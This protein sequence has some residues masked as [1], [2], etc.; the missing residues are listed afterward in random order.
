MAIIPAYTCRSTFSG[1]RMQILNKRK[2]FV[3]IALETGAH[4]V[5]VVGFGETDLFEISQPKP[6]GWGQK[7]QK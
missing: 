1:P 6:G 3:R 4:L 7:L 2:G 5:P